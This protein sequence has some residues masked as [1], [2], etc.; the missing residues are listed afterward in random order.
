[1]DFHIKRRFSR[2]NS[3]QTCSPGT[4][5]TLWSRLYSSLNPA[6]VPWLCGRKVPPHNRG[7]FPPLQNRRTGG[8]REP[9]HPWDLPQPALGI[10]WQMCPH[11][12]NSIPIPPPLLTVG[13]WGLSGTIAHLRRRGRRCWDVA[14]SLTS[15][16]GRRQRGANKGGPPQEVSCWRNREFSVCLPACLTLQSPLMLHLWEAI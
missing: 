15:Q 11:G 1:M 10:P 7:C 3:L 14:T 13:Q 2:D 9:S 5:I 16:W 12:P 8:Q 6:M 4:S